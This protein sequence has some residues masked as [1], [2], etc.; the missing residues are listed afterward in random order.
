MANASSLVQLLHNAAVEREPHRL[1]GERQRDAERR[2]DVEPRRTALRTAPYARPEIEADFAKG[3]DRMRDARRAIDIRLGLCAPDEPRL[4]I[5][6]EAD[7][8]RNRHR[9]NPA[10][11]A[12]TGP[13][14]PARQCEAVLGDDAQWQT[15]RLP[16]DADRGFAQPAAEWRRHAADKRDAMVSVER[17]DQPSAGLRSSELSAKCAGREP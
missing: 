14:L 5:G 4:H 1:L 10:D 16:F 15:S 9:S 12:D 17:I 8:G 13:A 7:A 3:R 2:A 6:L 11:H